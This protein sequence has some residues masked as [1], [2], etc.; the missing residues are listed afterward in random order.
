MFENTFWTDAVYRETALIISVFL[1]VVAGIVYFF[2]DKSTESQAVWASLKSWIFF[3]PLSFVAFAFKEPW[4]LIFLVLISIYSCK[5][6]FQMVGMYHRSWF[7]WIT[8]IY[9]MS[10]GYLVYEGRTELY[11]IMP[12]LLL[13]TAFLVPL[14]RNSAKTMIQYTAL[15]MMGFIFFGWSFLHLARLLQLENGIYLVIYIYILA[16]MSENSSHIAD[17]LFGKRKLFTKIT[18]RISI[19]G[20]AASLFFTILIAWAMRHLLPVRTE[21]YWLSAGVIATTI[22]HLGNLSISVI[23]RDLGL[24]NT[25]IFI[26]GRGDIID[27]M[28]KMIFIAPVFYYILLYLERGH[29]F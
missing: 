20:L 8:Y 4:Q 21:P 10:T 18:N 26:I 25:G 7:V 24:K 11:D 2:K 23:R 5:I 3:A 12:M 19:E 29:T 9:I 14:I 27:R 16:E 22:G 6:Y 17:T 28:D 13:G 1:F 15:T